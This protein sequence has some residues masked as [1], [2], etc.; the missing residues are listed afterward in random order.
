MKT[1]II[2][3]KFWE[4]SYVGTLN[5][6]EKLVF[7]YLLTNSRINLCGFYE[8]PDRIISFETGIGS[9]D[10]EKMKQKFQADGKFS[11][12]SGWVKVLNHEKYNQ[13]KGEKNE[14]AKEKEL[15]LIPQEIVEGIDTLSV[16]YRYPS[17]STR[18]HKS[19]IRNQKS[20][21]Q[22]PKNKLLDEDLEDLVEKFREEG[23]EVRVGYIKFKY[24][25]MLDWLSAKGK[26]YKD[27]KRGLS[28]WIRKDIENGKIKRI[29][30]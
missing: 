11:F 8:L 22:K 5:P 9:S 19:E 26:T 30:E 23:W 21:I 13:Y 12:H 29:Q 20:E 27:H 28:N 10:L 24:Q 16:P 15:S 18:N 4:D 17:D 3:T 7:V 6:T 2:Y 14:I 1:R 25:H